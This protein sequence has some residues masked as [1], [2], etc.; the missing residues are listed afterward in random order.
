MSL[1]LIL[2][3]G[4]W[5]EPVSTSLLVQKAL[6][7]YFPYM[8]IFMPFFLVMLG[9]STIISFFCV[10]QKCAEFLSPRYGRIVYFLYALVAFPLFTFV[11]IEQALIVMSISGALLLIINVSGIFKLRKEIEF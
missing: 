1:L 4:V 8:N 7:A 11:N 9:Y 10:G 2:V 6:S 3:T 5:Q